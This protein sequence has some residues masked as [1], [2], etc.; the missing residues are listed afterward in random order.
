ME[1][2]EGRERGLKRYSMS[3][4]VHKFATKFG[5]EALLTVRERV[6]G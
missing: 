5:V 6:T 4:E 3:D 2:Q 1:M